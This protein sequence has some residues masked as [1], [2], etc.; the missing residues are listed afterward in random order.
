MFHKKKL[1]FSSKNLIIF[2]NSHCSKICCMLSTH[3]NSTTCIWGKVSSRFWT[4]LWYEGPNVWAKFLAAQIIKPILLLFKN[5]KFRADLKP[6]MNISGPFSCCKIN[7]GIDSAKYSIAEAT[8]LSEAEAWS[9]ILL[10]HTE[11]I[12]F[13]N[14]FGMNFGQLDEFEKHI[15][16]ILNNTVWW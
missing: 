1:N 4:F 3:G 9:W 13:R 6:P 5:S 11:Q 2:F 7:D 16:S 12:F 15:C 8:S 10:W 14:G